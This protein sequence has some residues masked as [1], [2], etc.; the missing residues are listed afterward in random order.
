MER[1]EH[2]LLLLCARTRVEGGTAESLRQHARAAVDWDYLFL[3][4]RRHSLLPLLYWQLNATAPDLVPPDQLRR[5]RDDFRLH[6]ARN[7]YLT[8]ELERVVTLFE[9]EGVA[10]I[11]YKGPALAA[12]AYG[13]LALRRYV[14]LDVLVRREDLTRAKELLVRRGFQPRLSLTP[15][16]ERVLLRSQHNLPFTRED[17]L[18][19]VELHWEFAQPR[20]ASAGRDASVWSRLVDVKL[21]GRGVKSL[22]AED[23]LLALCVHGTK[24]LWERLA[25]VCDV[26]ELINSH[27]RLDWPSVLRQALETNTERMLLLGLN[28]ARELLDARVPADVSARAAAE[29]SVARLSAQVV[30]RLFDGTVHRPAGLFRQIGFNLRARRGLA[31]RLRYFSFIFTPTDGDLAALTLPANLSFVY[32]LLRPFR[33]LLLK[34][35]HGH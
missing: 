16:Q 9:S 8:G 35:D 26:A 17:G 34:G 27:P 32:Y 24:H 23:L 29:P 18:L 28:L 30:A 33:L 15:S 7:L 31:G 13:N 21:N 12:F 2:R 4:A 10:V 25:W 1:P 11:S 19:V 5:L 20:Y 6:T 3:L 14:D 22:A